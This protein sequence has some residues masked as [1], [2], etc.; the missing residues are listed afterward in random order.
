MNM[1]HWQVSS[2]I[3]FSNLDWSRYKV[4]IWM[5]IWNTYVCI[6]EVRTYVH[7]YMV[8]STATYISTHIQLYAIDVETTCVSHTNLHMQSH[9]CVASQNM[10]LMQLQS[11]SGAW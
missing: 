11:L 4:R 8:Q 5:S 7:M 2:T 10:Y 6:Y 9:A 3:L 1:C